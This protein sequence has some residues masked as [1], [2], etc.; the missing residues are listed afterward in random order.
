MTSKNRELADHIDDLLDIIPGG[1]DDV[2]KKQEKIEYLSDVPAD[3]LEK[4]QELIAVYNE[5]TQREG[6][7]TLQDFLD[8]IR[9]GSI[10]EKSI[11]IENLDDKLRDEILR[12]NTFGILNGDFSYDA[13]KDGLADLWEVESTG[14]VTN[15]QTSIVPQTGEGYLP[16]T[17]KIFVD[18][19]G[20][21]SESLVNL[22]Q[23]FPRNFYTN[24][25]YVNFLLWVGGTAAPTVIVTISWRSEID[26]RL[27]VLVERQISPVEIEANEKFSI[28]VDA[29]PGTAKYL[30]VSFSMPGGPGGPDGSHSFNVGFVELA[31]SKKQ[32]GSGAVSV[33]TGTDHFE[34]ITTLD[35]TGAVAKQES[36]N[37]LKV[38]ILPYSFEGD[39]QVMRRTHTSEI[40]LP[41]SSVSYLDPDDPTS[42]MVIVPEIGFSDGT[43]IINEASFEL[44][45][46]FLVSQGTGHGKI[47]LK[48]VPVKWQKDTFSAN[49]SL[50]KFGDG[51]H[52]S[53]AGDPNSVTVSIDPA[54][55]ELEKGMAFLAVAPR[56]IYITASDRSPI[57]RS[58][59]WFG[60]PVASTAGD[61]V[62]NATKK[63]ITIGKLDKKINYLIAVAIDIAD[64][65]ISNGFVRVFF[66]DHQSGG[67]SEYLIDINGNPVAIQMN[68]SAFD[69]PKQI[70]LAGIVSVSKPTDISLHIVSSFQEGARIATP[71]EGNSALLVQSL[72]S[73]I[74]LVP[75]F[76][77]YTNADL[78]WFIRDFKNPLASMS[79]ILN[80]P[81]AGRDYDIFS[82]A[83]EKN[84]L[85]EDGYVLTPMLNP[86]KAEIRDQTLFLSN[87]DD[88]L[89]PYFSFGYYFGQEETA[90]LRESAITGTLSLLPDDYPGL[91]MIL[92]WNGSGSLKEAQNPIVGVNNDEPAL[93]SNWTILKNTD[94]PG[95]STSAK[96]TA[97]VPSD[98]RLI[99]VLFCP[100]RAV[101]PISYE[102]SNLVITLEEEFT[103]A[104]IRYAKTK[105]EIEFHVK[106]FYE[107]FIQIPPVGRVYRYTINDIES[108]CPAGELKTKGLHIPVI[109]DQSV[110]Q[111]PGSTIKIGEG[112]IKF[113]Q[114]MEDVKIETT[115][116]V[117]AGESAP[118]GQTVPVT[119][120]WYKI[121]DGN[122]VPVEN[123]ENVVEVTQGKPQVSANFALYGT[124]QRNEILALRMKTTGKNFAY[125]Q[126]SNPHIPL[127]EN[128]LMQESLGA[129]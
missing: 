31:I 55:Y 121:V 79:G 43:N 110:N 13:N 37:R 14:S 42:K 20:E 83:G 65:I 9:N 100:A 94:V 33:I 5:K 47:S 117:Y 35:L 87:T 63:T 76:E 22:H 119:F 59:I 81:L 109:L 16:T 124:F 108:A 46:H 84:I 58:A 71:M 112:G 106:T 45:N 21:S 10:S 7:A 115:V 2:T 50:L 40:L 107:R 123:G 66:H 105:N 32:I 23:T 17:Q 38:D 120:T 52:A 12:G 53:Q 129:A 85:A 8:L 122:F 36:P 24:S 73:A 48:A 86:V 19:I 4:D 93:G 96:V 18:A 61:D 6:R 118:E 57:E 80:S 98:A 62:Y 92:S 30:D 127:I 116:Q 70:V 27:N 91:F 77:N 114:D 51:L 26:S 89:A 99:A 54:L 39:D 78:H 56:D 74:D 41:T 69:T 1:S 125:I 64:E 25:C 101:K 49:A 126:S 29:I 15:L 111:V 68:Y 90:L 11:K 128:I 95:L 88:G 34:D 60:T 67:E 102:I 103:G 72:D 82:Q 3:Q 104:I 28:K 113:N 44:D 75:S 97:E